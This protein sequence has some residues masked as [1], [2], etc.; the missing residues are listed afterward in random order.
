MPEVSVV[1]ATF[2]RQQSLNRCLEA[3]TQQTLRDFEVI[4]VDDHSTLP[5]ESNIEDNIAGRLNLRVIRLEQNSGPARARNVGVSAATA[6]YIAFVDDDISPSPELLSTHLLAWQE[7]A[8]A[9]SIILGP[10]LEPPDRRPTP[11]NLWEARQLEVQYSSM[12]SGVYAPTWR[13]FFT[14]NAFLRREDFLAVGGFDERFTRA[15]DVELGLRLWKHG[16]QFLFEPRAI[17]WHYSERTLQGWLKIPR[18]YGR[19]DVAIDELHPEQ[20]RLEVV[21]RELAARHRLTRAYGVLLG[22]ATTS[23]YGSA[24][25]VGAARLLFRAGATGPAMNALSVAFDTEYRAS[26][27]KALVQRAEYGTVLEYGHGRR[28]ASALPA[29]TAGPGGTAR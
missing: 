11:W 19:F 27:R 16:C 29:P 5:V 21:H 24:I 14:A 9:P 15:E 28:Q 4:V 20:D 23:R 3:L 25:A 2:N 22:G 12:L 6:P 1:V 17:A 18:E 26:L 10:M 7:A 8:P 13:Q